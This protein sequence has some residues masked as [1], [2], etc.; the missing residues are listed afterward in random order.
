MARCPVLRQVSLQ[1]HL[2]NPLAIK[3]PARVKLLDLRELH[4]N[5]YKVEV[6]VEEKTTTVLAK[7]GCLYQDSHLQ[8]HSS[9]F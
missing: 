2:N 9:L 5:S 6:A 4:T 3:C 7:D 1:G 8:P